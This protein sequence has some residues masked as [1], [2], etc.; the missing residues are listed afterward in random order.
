M[1][2][3][4]VR[5][6]GWACGAGEE[7]SDIEAAALLERAL[8]GAQASRAAVEALGAAMYPPQVPPSPL[9]PPLAC[10]RDQRIRDQRGR[11]R[12]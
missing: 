1:R 4:L 5:R 7:P 10:V 12:T 11:E 3:S 2:A 8:A 9:L 6:S